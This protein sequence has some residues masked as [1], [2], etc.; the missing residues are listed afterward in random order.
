MIVAAEEPP[1]PR[2]WR[3]YM[4]RHGRS[5]SF[6]A[7]F[8][9]PSERA[10]V[11]AVYAWCRYTDDI[12]DHASDAA[13]A[14]RL[15]DWLE[16]SR[17]A[18]DGESTGIALLDRV[19]TMARQ[20]EVPFTYPAELI[21]GM[22]MDLRHQPYESLRDLKL[23]RWRVAGTVGV[24]LTELY[25]VREPWVLERAAMLGE[26]M[27]LTNIIRDV[28]EDL[29]RGRLYLPLELMRAH[30]I[31]EGSLRR[32]RSGDGSPGDGWP[33]LVE[34]LIAIAE[35]D[36]AHAMAAL[37]ALPRSFRRT[38]TIAAS[39]YAGIHE[40]VRRIGYDTLRRRATTSSVEKLAL[41]A[42]ALARPPRRWIAAGGA[43]VAGGSPA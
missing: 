9:S 21:A 40:A 30:G 11:S 36:Y 14:T 17:A 5:F 26:A 13:V 18:Y 32:A 6:A 43:L 27:Q 31:S 10:R 7:A 12:V 24:W 19:M 4:Q 23:Y 15:D 20:A 22:R 25:G 8:M 37:P 16:R 3:G 1:A 2:E 34:E 38:V 33:A 42:R 39:V 28:G 35:R 29:S 41:A